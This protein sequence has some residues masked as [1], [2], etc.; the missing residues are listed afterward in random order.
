MERCVPILPSLL[1]SWVGANDEQIDYLD[2]VTFENSADRFRLLY[3]VKGRFVLH[4]I[5]ENESQVRSEWLIIMSSSNC[6]RL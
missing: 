4:R 5:D 6:A 1:V 3:D 2:V